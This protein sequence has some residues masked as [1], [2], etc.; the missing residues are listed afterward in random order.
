MFTSDIPK[1]LRRRQETYFRSCWQAV[2]IW[3]NP[4]CCDFPESEPQTYSFLHPRQMLANTSGDG[5]MRN[6]LPKNLISG[7]ECNS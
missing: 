4:A 7:P 3:S 1:T 2:L 5:P 6:I